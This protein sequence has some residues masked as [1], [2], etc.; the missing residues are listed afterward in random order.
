VTDTTQ[1]SGHTEE[2]DTPLTPSFVREI[3]RALDRG[4][5]EVVRSLV[6]PLRPADQAELL[7]LVRSDELRAL[8]QALGSDLEP[9]VLSEL[10]EAVRDD[11]IELMAPEDIAA[12][13]QEMD[14]DDAVYILEDMPAEEQR[15]VLDQVPAQVRA[16]I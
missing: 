8:V 12:A 14:S 15:E 11:V 13:V 7:E 9:D 5:E 4:D 3:V 16:A 10:E 1:L 6:M 2:W